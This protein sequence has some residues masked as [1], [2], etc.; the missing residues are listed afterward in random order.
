M[1]KL[2]RFCLRRRVN[3]SEVPTHPRMSSREPEPVRLPVARSLK[4]P[5]TNPVRA[6]EILSSLMEM[7][8][9]RAISRFGFI[10]LPVVIKINANHIMTENTIH[11]ITANLR[12]L[13]VEIILISICLTLAFK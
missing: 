4:K 7:Q 10:K 2:R 12:F 8:S 11:L 13:L 6:A 9:A 3:S 1:V 5:H